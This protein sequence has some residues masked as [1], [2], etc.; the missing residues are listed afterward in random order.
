MKRLCK[1]RIQSKHVICLLLFC[2]RNEIQAMTNTHPDQNVTCSSIVSHSDPQ[3]SFGF[4]YTKLSGDTSITFVLL[5][6]DE[7]T[8]T[9]TV[10]RACLQHNMQI[11]VSDR[12]PVFQSRLNY[13]LHT[14]KSRVLYLKSKLYASLQHACILSGVLS[15]VDFSIVE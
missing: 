5:K 6:S 14:D 8:E 4:F 10:L 9:F 3:L 2:F 11:N 15:P 7:L 1:I 13:K 12:R